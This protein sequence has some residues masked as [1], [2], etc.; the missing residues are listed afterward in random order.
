M[1]KPTTSMIFSEKF[2]R[3]IF[4]RDK[5]HYVQIIDYLIQI[6]LILDSMQISITCVQ[7]SDL[8]YLFAQM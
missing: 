1:H 2:F 8:G 4:C 3:I 6:L 5:Q 7:I